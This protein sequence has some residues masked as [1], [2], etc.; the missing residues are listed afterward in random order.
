MRVVG[1]MREGIMRV[2]LLYCNDRMTQAKEGVCQS[3]GER[4]IITVHNH[5]VLQYGIV[6]GSRNI[7][8][9]RDTI[10]HEGVVASVSSDQRLPIPPRYGQFDA[11]A[12]GDGV[13]VL[14]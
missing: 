1:L 13:R 3:E 8:K 12:N 9:H 5:T 4:F 10:T 7:P 11:V 14:A 6:C 2:T